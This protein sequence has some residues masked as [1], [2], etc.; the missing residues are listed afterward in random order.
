MCYLMDEGPAA[1]VIDA[2]GL[3]RSEGAAGKLSHL[4]P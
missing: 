2:A 4:E 1:L 3:K